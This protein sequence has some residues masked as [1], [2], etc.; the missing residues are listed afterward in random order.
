MCT[1]LK[2]KVKREEKDER[3]ER[4]SFVMPV[5]KLFCVVCPI[6]P[7]I[8]GL[9]R[10]SIINVNLDHCD[11]ERQKIATGMSASS[12]MPE[13]PGLDYKMRVCVMCV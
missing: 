1:W 5:W 10:N 4:N 11:P 9:Y 3:R 8:S 7:L 13:K 2:S 6:L 12:S